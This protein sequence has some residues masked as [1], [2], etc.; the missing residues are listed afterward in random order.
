VPTLLAVGY[1]DETT[2]AAA[3]DEVRRSARDLRLEPEAIAVVSRNEEGGYQVDTNHRAVPGGATSAVF[4][5]RLFGDLFF[6]PGL[7]GRTGK[8]AKDTVDRE[9][10]SQVRDLLQPSASVLFLVVDRGTQD[11]AV[12]RLQRYGGTALTSSLSKDIALHPERRQPLSVSAPVSYP[13]C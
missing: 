8:V 11:E 7:G 4:W 5:G 3:G 9:F 2:A 10:P 12:E 6:G 1:P 13:S